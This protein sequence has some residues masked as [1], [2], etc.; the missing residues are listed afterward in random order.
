[1]ITRCVDVTVNQ[2]QFS[3]FPV[4]TDEQKETFFLVGYVEA[5]NTNAKISYTELKDDISSEIN[6]V[7]KNAL[8]GMVMPVSQIGQTSTPVSTC[9]QCSET[10][11]ACGIYVKEGIYKVIQINNDASNNLL[12]FAITNEDGSQTLPINH[13]HNAFKEGQEQ[14]LLLTAIPAEL[15]LYSDATTTSI[16]NGDFF[17]SGNID[18]GSNPKIDVLIKFLSVVNPSIEVE[19]GY[20]K[21]MEPAFVYVR[22]ANNSKD[23]TKEFL[24]YAVYTKINV[25]SLSLKELDEKIDSQIEQ[26]SALKDKVL[27][28]ILANDESD[29]AEKTASLSDFEKS[30]TIVLMSKL[31]GYEEKIWVPFGNG[32]QGAWEVLGSFQSTL[33]KPILVDSIDTN[34]GTKNGSVRLIYK[35]TSKNLN[36]FIVAGS[37]DNPIEGLAVHPLAICDLE[38]RLQAEIDSIVGT[39]SGVSIEKLSSDIAEVKVSVEELSNK[40]TTFEND[41]TKYPT[42]DEINNAYLSKETARDTYATNNK[43]N[44]LHIQILGYKY[45]TNAE[46]MATYATKET[47]ITSYVA[48]TDF[49]SKFNNYAT[50]TVTTDLANKIDD[51]HDELNEYARKDTDIA[52]INSTIADINSNILNLSTSLSDTNTKLTEFKASTENSITALNTGIMA[53]DQKLQNINTDIEGIKTSVTENTQDIKDL[54]NIVDELRGSGL[55]P[56][57]T[58]VY[59]ITQDNITYDE[60]SATVSIDTTK[61]MRDKKITSA[62]YEA[63][64]SQVFAKDVLDDETPFANIIPDCTIKY[65]S[66][67]GEQIQITAPKSVQLMKVVITLVHVENDNLQN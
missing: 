59:R 14:W 16:Y 60:N 67:M 63:Y 11:K 34:D 48:K 7:N 26:S 57:Y 35:F 5:D 25:N 31:F 17:S 20:Y 24:P 50:V 45:I 66:T 8:S 27:N 30:R 37:T 15:K 2:T 39:S 32:G 21:T 49:E 62:E 33:A 10:G 42:R 43:L 64:V 46:A 6:E 65:Y 38:N 53:H 9:P 29:F 52:T 61:L 47:L 3:D 55:A 19:E 18:A 54:E 36:D 51:I 4:V 23:V 40:V 13:E 58:F 12:N 22:N 56:T 44:E 1:M 28:V 41:I